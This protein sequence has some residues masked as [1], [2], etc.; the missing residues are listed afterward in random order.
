MLFRFTHPFDA[1]G[2]LAMLGATAL[3]TYGAAVQLERLPEVRSLQ[4]SYEFV[5]FAGAVCIAILAW[6]SLRNTVL[7]R[8]LPTW[9]WCR[10]AVGVK[11]SPATADQVTFL[12]DGSM[13]V[14]YSKL[15]LRNAPADTRLPLLFTFANAVARERGRPLPFPQWDAMNTQGHG[16]SRSNTSTGAGQSGDSTSQ[17]KQR[18]ERERAERARREQAEREA[19]ERARQSRREAD[20]A[21]RVHLKALDLDT[22]PSTQAALREAYTRKL[23]QYHPDLFANERPEVQ[24]MANDLTRGINEAFQV[25]SSAM[26]GGK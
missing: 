18:A 2:R 22:L 16:Q 10:T 24:R 7:P 23:R 19:E 3:L 9:L 26:E 13:G 15:R 1:L 5:E 6:R 20:A 11:V 17:S 8:W 21:L 25:L 14:W 12:F 4:R